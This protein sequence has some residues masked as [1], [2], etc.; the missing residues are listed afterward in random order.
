MPTVSCTRRIDAPASLVFEV[1]TD[2]E[3]AAER[4]RGINSLEVLTDG[5]VG[6]GTRFRETRTMFG[7]QATETMEIVAFDPPHSYSVAAASCGAQYLSTLTFRPD[8]SATVVEMTFGATPQT[9]MARLMTFILGGLMLK[10]CRKMIQ[11]DLDDLAAAAEGRPAPVA[12][13]T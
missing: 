1:F 8:G 5:P 2:L 10:A 12:A 9:F 7:K 13:A 3:N 11:Q 6:K 4:V